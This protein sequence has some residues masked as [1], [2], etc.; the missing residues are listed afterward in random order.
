MILKSEEDVFFPENKKKSNKV[1]QEISGW[2]M[3]CGSYSRIAVPR[4]TF[5]K[6]EKNRFLIWSMGVCVPNLRSVSFF[7]WQGCMTHTHTRTHTEIC[8]SENRNTPTACSPSVDFEKKNLIKQFFSI[9]TGFCLTSWLN[10]KMTWG[11]LASKSCRVTWVPAYLFFVLFW[12]ERDS[13]VPSNGRQW[14]IEIFRTKVFMKHYF[15]KV[16]S[17][18]VIHLFIQTCKLYSF[19]FLNI[20]CAQWKEQPFIEIVSPQTIRVAFHNGLSKSKNTLSKLGMRSLNLL[21]T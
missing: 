4:V 1:I 8:T 14:R 9:H 17:V 18:L 6:K 7:V 19:I 21:K 20:L 13:N 10:E 15:V 2:S 5:W 3:L 16:K 11:P 12:G